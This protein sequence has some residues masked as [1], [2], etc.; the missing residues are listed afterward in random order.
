[1]PRLDAAARNELRR[2]IADFERHEANE[3]RTRAL[4]QQVR[5]VYEGA[6]LTT[7]VDERKLTLE[8]HDGALGHLSR[9]VD[10]KL[11]V[12]ALYAPLVLRDEASIGLY[13]PKLRTL[14]LS[15]DAIARGQAT[16]TELH[17]IRHAWHHHL[18][19]TGRSTVLDAT[20]VGDAPF[21]Q[22]GG[23]EAGYFLDELSAFAYEA[24]ASVSGWRRLEALAARGQATERTLRRVLPSALTKIR[25]SLDTFAGP[26]LARH[27]ARLL[28]E[29]AHGLLGAGAWTLSRESPAGR[30]R[31]FERGDAWLRFDPTCIS[32][33]A[34]SAT[35]T[36]SLHTPQDLALLREGAPKL[37][38]A[39]LILPW[40][41]RAEAVARTQAQS[42]D[43]LRRAV[44]ETDRALSDG[45]A[46]RPPL[47]RVL[48]ELSAV[49]DSVSLAQ[50]ER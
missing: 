46:L 11:S 17:E 6:G 38:V 45:T 5:D 3:P 2:L 19:S 34:G 42:Y 47:T 44:N 4:L 37:I 14:F 15:S 20:I 13:D 21:S 48:R 9:G 22:V 8:V 39:R 33:H 43:R 32:V 41:R 25:A 29:V 26:A 10:D 23:Y 1:M 12:R 49:R 16:S 36:L 40:L 7:R 18:R 28:G 27:S 35:V 24:R 31:V 50:I 30:V